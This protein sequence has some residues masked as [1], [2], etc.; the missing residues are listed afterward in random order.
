MGCGGSLTNWFPCW[1]EG[2]R[3]FLDAHSINVG[4]RKSDNAVLTF[5]SPPHARCGIEVY[6]DGGAIS[7][8]TFD[9]V[10]HDQ[11]PKRTCVIFHCISNAAKGAGPETLRATWRGADVS[12]GPRAGH[13]NIGFRCALSGAGS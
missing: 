10:D 12:R 13:H 7:V 5:L 11:S 2:F 8:R 3:P 9:P 1:Y 4:A 6:I